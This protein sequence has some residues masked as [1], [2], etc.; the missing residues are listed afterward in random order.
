VNL[1]FLNH[2]NK[3]ILY[4]IVILHLLLWNILGFYKLLASIQTFFIRDEFLVMNSFRFEL[5]NIAIHFVV[6]E[7]FL[8]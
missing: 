6:S 4:F 7:S 8:V 5:Y 3:L 1:V 2:K